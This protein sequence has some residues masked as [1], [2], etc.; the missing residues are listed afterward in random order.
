MTSTGQ[1]TKMFFMNGIVF[2]TKNI[3]KKYKPERPHTEKR[4]QRNNGMYG[5]V[6][7]RNTKKSEMSIPGITLGAKKVRSAIVD[8]KRHTPNMPARNNIGAD[9][10]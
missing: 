9:C 4:I 7:M 5:G 2:T 6:V 8:M 1:N 3:V 10:L